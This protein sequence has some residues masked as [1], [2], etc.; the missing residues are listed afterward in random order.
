M[1]KL[2]ILARF[3]GAVLVGRLIGA[4]VMATDAYD[5][6]LAGGASSGVRGRSV[7]AA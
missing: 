4:G 6:R 3:F 2:V 7:A 5:R 1:L